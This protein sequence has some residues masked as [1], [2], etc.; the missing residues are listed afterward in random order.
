M[1]RPYIVYTQQRNLNS[2]TPTSMYIYNDLTIATTQWSWNHHKKNSLVM[3][4]KYDPPFNKIQ[5]CQSKV[6]AKNDPKMKR[7]LS[8]GITRKSRLQSRRSKPLA[9][10]LKKSLALTLRVYRARTEL[11]MPMYFSTISQSQIKRQIKNATTRLRSRRIGRSTSRK[12]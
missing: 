8:R 12:S 11:R 7:K 3:I 9:S 4:W 5:V 2:K 1:L 10:P 6:P